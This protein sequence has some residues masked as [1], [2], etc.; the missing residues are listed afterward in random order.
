MWQIEIPQFFREISKME[1]VSAAAAGFFPVRISSNL[2]LLRTLE[3]AER[4]LEDMCRSGHTFGLL[5]P[6]HEFS[7]ETRNT[8]RVAL[9]MATAALEKVKA[10]H[11][12]VDLPLREVC[13]SDKMVLLLRNR[14]PEIRTVM[15]LWH[16][17]ETALEGIIDQAKHLGVPHQ[18]YLKLYNA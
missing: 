7:D 13:A 3:G 9:S 5:P 2:I 18:F 15:D 14:H 16:F 10:S 8:L 17:D 6:G 1:A 11:H 12:L 4:G